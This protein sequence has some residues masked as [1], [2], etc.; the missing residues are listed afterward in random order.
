MSFRIVEAPKSTKYLRRNK[1]LL[2]RR[3]A[4]NNLAVAFDYTNEL[5]KF[6]NAMRSKSEFI[7]PRDVDLQGNDKKYIG[8]YEF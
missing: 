2:I 3:P 7:R 1:K 5:D 6:S 4:Q 8:I